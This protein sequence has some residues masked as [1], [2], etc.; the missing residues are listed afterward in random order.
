MVMN[1]ALAIRSLGKELERDFFG[2]YDVAFYTREKIHNGNIAVAN[3]T[4]VELFLSGIGL[5]LFY[6]RRDLPL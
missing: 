4:F 2:G 6:F 5:F 1:G 3:N